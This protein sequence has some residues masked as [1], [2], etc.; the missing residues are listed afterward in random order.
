MEKV[1]S[2]VYSWVIILY[3][4]RPK[5]AKA[6]QKRKNKKSKTEQFWKLD[7]LEIDQEEGERTPNLD[8]KPFSE[9]SERLHEE[10]N[11]PYNPEKQHI[12]L[13]TPEHETNVKLDKADQIDLEDDHHIISDKNSEN[14]QINPQQISDIPQIEEF[15]G[16]QVPT[17][18]N[19]INDTP[20]YHGL[21]KEQYER[22]YTT[23]KIFKFLMFP[24]ILA[25]WFYSRK[26]LLWY[27]DVRSF[28]CTDQ[29]NYQIIAGYENKISSNDIFSV[30]HF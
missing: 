16:L 15:K 7:F 20:R 26:D 3:H 11:F 13:E 5:R 18:V 23:D 25:G 4:T 19:E 10:E 14:N 21:T 24:F 8:N 17:N 9:E 1:F 2:S 30:F 28:D 22:H 12:Q 27:Q 6:T 29:V